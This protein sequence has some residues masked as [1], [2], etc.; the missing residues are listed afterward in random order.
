MVKPVFVIEV[1]SL[2]I[3]LSGVITMDWYED[4]EK[5]RSIFGEDRTVYR[6]EYKGYELEVYPVELIDKKLHGWEYIIRNDSV[7]YDSI[8]ETNKSV[9]YD[10]L[11]ETIG[12]PH[13]ENYKVAMEWARNTLDLLLDE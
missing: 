1:K 7:D 2:F 8:N 10:S 3:I 9:Y 13:A 6:T 4:T 11:R 12:F 5:A